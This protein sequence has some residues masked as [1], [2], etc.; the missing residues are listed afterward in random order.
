[1]YIGQ[2][3]AVPNFV[4]ECTSDPFEQATI[5]PVIPM[6]TNINPLFP[7]SEGWEQSSVTIKLPPPNTRFKFWREEDAPTV[8]ID[9][10]HHCS[11]VKSLEFTLD[12]HA[13]NVFDSEVWT[14]QYFINEPLEIVNCLDV[15][16]IEPV[17]ELKC[18]LLLVGFG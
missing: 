2:S 7:P 12:I 4:S 5:P 13:F 16:S 15:I 6:T 17:N 8:T 10:I 3:E 11:F 1:M 14:E 18:W 9:G